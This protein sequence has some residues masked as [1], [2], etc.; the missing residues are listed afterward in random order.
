MCERRFELEHTEYPRQLS[1][2]HHLSTLQPPGTLSI[3]VCLPLPH[4][5]ALQP[6]SSRLPTDLRSFD[7]Q[8][9]TSTPYFT[10]LDQNVRAAPVVVLPPKP[11]YFLELPGEIRNKIYASLFPS[12]TFHIKYLTMK[13]KTLSYRSNHN[14]YT[15]GPYMAPG[16][17][18][19]ISTEVR[20]RE[21]DRKRWMK[22]MERRPQ[23]HITSGP[24]AFLHICRVVNEET[25]PIF[26]GRNWFV[27]E[28]PWTLRTFVQ[29]M[30]DSTQATIKNVKLKH[31]T[32]GEPRYTKDRP[33]KTRYDRAW[34]KFCTSTELPCMPHNL[35]RLSLQIEIRDNPCFLNMEAEWVKPL[36]ALGNRS[37]RDVSI[38]L[39][40]IFK[41][42]EELK[43]CGEVL[44][45]E[46]L[47]RDYREDEQETTRLRNLLPRS[48]QIVPARPYILA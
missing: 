2:T 7:V 48:L 21:F 25:S 47:G 32:H 8:E 39:L 26:Y 28:D 24:T 31:Q 41:S 22:D 15:Q 36:L 40:S 13:H 45:R 6:L 38:I 34:C 27:F 44:R 20:R 10:E 17:K 37:L 29:L 33:F 1:I 16:T 3:R 43:A 4:T 14:K 11:C 42:D 9:T 46:L 5:I 35:E 19:A 23:Y 12:D 30:R 18:L